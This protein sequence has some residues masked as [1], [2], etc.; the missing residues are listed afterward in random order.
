MM[1]IA[2]LL[3]IISIEPHSFAR[4]GFDEKTLISVI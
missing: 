2:I 1:K 4:S 3:I